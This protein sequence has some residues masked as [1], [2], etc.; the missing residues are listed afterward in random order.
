MAKV[1]SAMMLAQVKAQTTAQ[2]A[3]QTR[4]HKDE[5]FIREQRR[6]D[7]GTFAQIQRDDETN[8]AKVKAMKA[9]RE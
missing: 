9:S 2:K 4:K 6:Q 8:K 7:A 5:A 3:A 1:Q